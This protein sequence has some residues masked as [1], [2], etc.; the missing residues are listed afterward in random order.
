MNESVNEALGAWLSKPGNS[1]VLAA[2]KLNIG[3]GTLRYRLENPSSWKWEE[4]KVVA[5]MTG[6]KVTDLQ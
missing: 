5:S 4:V 2:R 1:Q 6:R 3:E